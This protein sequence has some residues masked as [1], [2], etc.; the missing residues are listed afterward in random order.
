MPL[1]PIKRKVMSGIKTR[2]KMSK[3]KRIKSI[4]KKKINCL[5]K[6]K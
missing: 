6:E 1:K 3:K 5:K 2:R 4:I